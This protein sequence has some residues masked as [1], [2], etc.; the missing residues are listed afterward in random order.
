MAATRAT[1]RIRVPPDAP[2]QRRRH[3]RP[4]HVLTLLRRMPGPRPTGPA[5]ARAYARVD[6][7]HVSRVS[8]LHSG[9][10]AGA[11]VVFVHGCPGSAD[12]WRAYLRETPAG[13]S[14]VA[15]DRPGFGRSDPAGAVASLQAQAAAVASLV[16]ERKAVLVGHSLGGSIVARAAVDY[17]ERVGALVIVAGALDPSLERIHPAQRLGEWGPIRQL[18]PRAVRNA[19]REL[20]ALQGELDALAP[21]LASITAPT[22]VVHGTRDNL[23]PFA[24]VAFMEEAMIGCPLEI[25]ELVD[26]NHFLPWHSRA[27]VEAAID[28]AFERMGAG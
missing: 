19:N 9:D 16:G 18:L 3:F 23:V 21:A 13:R 15:I 5:P 11:R 27:L 20:L 25:F 24:N 12:G 8:Y 17:P 28:R 2:S 4:A 22:F 10:P 14:H 26:R 7:Q 1:L 6:H